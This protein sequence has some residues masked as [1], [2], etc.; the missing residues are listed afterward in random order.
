MERG[1]DTG[2]HGKMKS[3]V[4]E[5]NRNMF[6]RVQ[7]SVNDRVKWSASDP[8]MYH[9]ILTGWLENDDLNMAFSRKF[10]KY[11]QQFR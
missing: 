9:G 8:W 2:E 5:R 1:E 4:S 7:W 10:G 6:I 11:F 3:I